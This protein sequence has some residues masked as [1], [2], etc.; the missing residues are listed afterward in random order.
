[1]ELELELECELPDREV[2]EPET[3]DSGELAAL[4]ASLKMVGGDRES[5]VLVGGES[6]GFGREK[7]KAAC[8]S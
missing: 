5:R 2:D 4:G 7:V 1:V 6:S 3:K 8:L